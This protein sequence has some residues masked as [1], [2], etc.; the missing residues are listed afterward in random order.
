I[1]DLFILFILFYFLWVFV[2]LSFGIFLP[3]PLVLLFVFFYYLFFEV[4]SVK[5]P[6][7]FVIGMKV[8]IVD[9]TAPTG[10]MIG[11]RSISSLILFLLFILF[12]FLLVF[13]F[14]I[15]GIFLPL[16]LVLL[17]VFFYYL[18]FEVVS[19]KTPGK[20]V[21]GT[22]VYTVDGTAPTG[23][24]IALRSISRFIPFDCL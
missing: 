17:F 12:Y 10:K 8:Y 18:F 16:P 5:M 4:V 24:M 13:V 1:F 9:G 21:T 3:L 7:K 15:F 22:K 2:F 14:L 6:G 20:F 19:G 23:K 11:L